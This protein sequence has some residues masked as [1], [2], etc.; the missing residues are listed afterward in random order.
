MI[1]TCRTTDCENA[2]HAIDVGDITY[3]DPDTGETRTGGVTCGVCAQPITDLSG[4]P[5]APTEPEPE[6][7]EEAEDDA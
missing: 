6:P 4:E 3:Q 7:I 2:G 1:A 5:A